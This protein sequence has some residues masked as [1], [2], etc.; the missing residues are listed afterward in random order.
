MDPAIRPADLDDVPAIRAIL[1][2]H[3]NDGPVVVADIV[4]P[5]VTHLLGRG[6]ACVATVDGEV[7]GF[8]AGVDT[9]RSVHLADLFVAADRLGRGIGRP[10]LAA[11][12]EGASARTTFASEDERALPL[13]VRA[14]MIPLWPS[15]YVQGGSANLPTIGASITTEPATEGELATLERAWTGLDRSADH[16]Y[17]ASM[18]DVDA[19]VVR[20]D[21]A[22]A[23]LGY[24]RARQ[25]A[26]IR[27]LDRL[28]VHPDADAVAVSIEAMRRASRGGPFRVCLPGPHP[29]LRPLLEAGL[30]IVDRDQF[31]ASEADL[32]DPVRL[33][34][35]PGML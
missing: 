35:N 6:R 22:V 24:A 28:V 2:A 4:G 20:Q 18:P 19:F 15:L 7:V 13:Y 32:V 11:V 23:A 9:G 27:V 17:W 30:R 26:A 1:A 34:P 14:G 3:G 5:Y 29:V 10:L 25:A 21:G 12:L 8:G 16:R 33:I 31:L